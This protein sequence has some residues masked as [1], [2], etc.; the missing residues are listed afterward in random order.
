[1]TC[2]IV[3]GRWGD[4]SVLHPYYLLYFVNFSKP[5][6]CILFSL[7]TGVML[8]WPSFSFISLHF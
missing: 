7:G 5:P 1:M 8:F 2:E 3:E 6:S 4:I